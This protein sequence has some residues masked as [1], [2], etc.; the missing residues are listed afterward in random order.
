MYQSYKA[1]RS[2]AR[3]KK[4]IVEEAIK[5]RRDV[6]LQFTRFS[7]FLQIWQKTGMS[8]SVKL[9]LRFPHK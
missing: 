5:Q 7:M 4:L 2:K 3:I 9:A 1:D 8:A 6:H